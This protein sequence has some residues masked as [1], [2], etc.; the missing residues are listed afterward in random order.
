MSNIINVQEIEVKQISISE[1]KQMVLLHEGEIYTYFDKG[2]T[3]FVY[4]NEENTK[5]LKMNIGDC[6]NYNEDEVKIYENASDEDKKRMAKPILLS[7]G[8]VEQEFCLPIKYGGMKLTPEQRSF[9]SQCRSEVG[10]NDDGELLC[11]DLDEYMKY[12]EH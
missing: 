8:I 12:I 9:A 11:F 7:N 5:V 4:T 3:R 6:I 1:A 10:W 2:C